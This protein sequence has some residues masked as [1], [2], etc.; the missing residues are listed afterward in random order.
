MQGLLA[1][2]G[3]IKS[4]GRMPAPAGNAR[5]SIVD[6]RDIAAVAAEAL[7]QHRHRGKSYDITGPESLAHADLA[8]QL[9]TVLGKEVTFVDIP[10]SATRDA[11]LSFGFPACKPMDLS[12]ITHTIAV[13]K[14]RPS[15][16]TLQRS[17]DVDLIHFCNSRDF[18]TILLRC[19]TLL[20][21]VT[22]VPGSSSSEE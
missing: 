7:T 6:V 21:S 18:G 17:R 16:L 19:R 13:E 8:A 2:E 1:L 20:L 14:P 9:S 10:E 15:P 4:D 22:G 12:K 3:S 5:V 11:L